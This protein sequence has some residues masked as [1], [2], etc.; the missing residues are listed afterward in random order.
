MPNPVV[1]LVKWCTGRR[2]Y[3][4]L[5][6]LS[7]LVFGIDLIIPDVIPFADEILLGLGTVVLGS[8]KQ[9]RVTPE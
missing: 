4:R 2:R 5:L 7:A 8:L 6:L 1:G 9:R 3:P